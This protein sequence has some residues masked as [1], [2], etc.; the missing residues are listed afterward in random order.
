MPEQEQQ[1]PDS[2]AVASDDPIA[3]IQAELRTAA[4]PAYRRI[5]RA[6]MR[7]YVA[8]LNSTQPQM[9]RVGYV[10]QLMDEAAD[11]YAAAQLA[12][13]AAVRPWG[14]K[15]QMAR[16]RL[17]ERAAVG[18]EALRLIEELAAIDSA[19]GSGAHGAADVPFAELRTL[20]DRAI[21][22]MDAYETM[23]AGWDEENEADQAALNAS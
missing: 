22:F 15:E 12:L 18:V 10:N 17:L 8:A 20:R 7:M 4:A 23:R 1:Q 19:A 21:V 3:R 11:E 2:S 14:E 16:K 5:G 9:G 13:D 6:V